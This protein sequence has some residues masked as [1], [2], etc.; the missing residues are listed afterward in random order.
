MHLKANAACN[1]MLTVLTKL[2]DFSRSQADTNA[3]KW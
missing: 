2:K 3:E 1:I